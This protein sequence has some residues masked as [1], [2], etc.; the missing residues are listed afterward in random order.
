MK[1]TTVDAYL[2]EG[3]GRCSD[4]QTPA[5]KVHR[6][7]PLL[8]RLR[9]LALEAGLEEHVKW[10]IPCYTHE[11]RNLVT[12]AAFRDEAALSF[13]VGEHLPDPGGILELPG[14]NT[15]QARIVRLRSEEQLAEREAA[16]RDLLAA[17]VR[18]PLPA[19]P[20][21]EETELPEELTDL[22]AGDPDLAAAFE[23]LT[24]GRQRSF[25]LHVGG[26]KQAKTR[27]SRAERCIPKILAGKGFNER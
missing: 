10:G 1:P 23:A 6:W 11:G 21:R 7:H 13:F 15:R 20:A 19:P 8:V 16:L 17:V 25:A 14:P 9:A 24:P 26:A 22:L 27:A 5:C 12:V 18:L 4:F 2:L 3:C